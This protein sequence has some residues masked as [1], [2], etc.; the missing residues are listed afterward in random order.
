QALRSFWIIKTL[1]WCSIA[2]SW[3]DSALVLACGDLPRP[4]RER[5][6]K[7]KPYG[8]TAG[9]LCPLG[10]SVANRW[11]EGGREPL[12]ELLLCAVPRTGSKWFP[13]FFPAF[14][15]EN[16]YAASARLLLG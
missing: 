13:R 1:G 15:P 7:E 16:G 14:P 4:G 11:K 6:R 12:P 8:C 3:S 10:L 2:P 9:L 5:A